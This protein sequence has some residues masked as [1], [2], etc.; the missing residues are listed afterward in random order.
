MLGIIIHTNKP[1][2]YAMNFIMMQ[3]IFYRKENQIQ[4]YYMFKL[5]KGFMVYM[6]GTANSP[7]IFP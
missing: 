2:E 6:W 4:Y 3:Y 1:V 7:T 5:K